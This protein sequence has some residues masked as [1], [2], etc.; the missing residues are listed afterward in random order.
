M[1]R[2]N[3]FQIKLQIQKPSIVNFKIRNSQKFQSIVSFFL[4]KDE[5]SKH[6]PKPNIHQKKLMVTAW[7][8]FMKPSQSITAETYC[9][10]LDNMIK[11]LTEKQ[12]RLVNRDRL[13]LLH[14]IARPHTANRTQL[15]ILKLYLENMNHPPYSSDLSPTDYHSQE[16]GND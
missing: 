3:C 11:N 12:P 1:F 13:I 16:K 6:S 5:V 15:K 8:S 4:G 9:N 7:W 2:C 14:N 10:Q